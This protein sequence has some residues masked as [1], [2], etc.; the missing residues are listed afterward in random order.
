MIARL[1][2]ENFFKKFNSLGIDG[3]L[4]ITEFPLAQLLIYRDNTDKILHNFL[5][6]GKICSRYEKPENSV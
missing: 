3:L 6:I 1:G 4:G 5:R 2:I